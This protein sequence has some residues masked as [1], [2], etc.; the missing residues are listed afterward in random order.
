MLFALVVLCLT[1]CGG[2]TGPTPLVFEGRLPADPGPDEGGRALAEDI[3]ADG[4]VTF[5]EYERAFTAGVQCMRDAGFEVEGPLRYP[6]GALLIEPG[7]D[8]RNRLTLRALNTDRGDGI[9]HFGPVNERCEAQWYYAVER[10]W[11]EQWEP[12]QAEIDAWLERAWTCAGEMG[13][14]LS[15]PPTD[16]E[17]M[18]AVAYG[19]QPWLADD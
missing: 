2:Q 6:D 4:E 15:S 14:P 10:L 1:A 5:D 16:H 8:P 11:D 3:F 18:D 12:T 17:A 19:C 7:V 9:D 13:L